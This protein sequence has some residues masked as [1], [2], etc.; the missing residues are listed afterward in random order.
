LNTILYL[1]EFKNKWICYI[2]WCDIR[3][4]SEV[5][6]SDCIRNIAW[7]TFLLRNRDKSVSKVTQFLVILTI[8]PTR[9]IKF[10][11]LLFGNRILHVID[12]ISVHHQ[13]SSTVHTAI[14]ICHTGYADSLLAGS[15]RNCCVYGTR[16]WMT[17][18][19]PVRN[20]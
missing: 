2:F 1:K 18:R 5:L 9:C 16:L 6:F 7:N 12:S 3:I 19:K 15:G 14:G 11:N 10:S 20:V 13:V 8:K 17:D 4:L